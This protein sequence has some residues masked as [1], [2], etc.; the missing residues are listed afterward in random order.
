M[1]PR[2]LVLKFRGDLTFRPFYNW[3]PTRRS[4]GTARYVIGVAGIIIT[5]KFPR[6]LLLREHYKRARRIHTSRTNIYITNQSV[7]LFYLR[8]P[9]LESDVIFFFPLL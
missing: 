5:Q 7:T 4:I 1:T 8:F 9:Q 3:K 6:A 2:E